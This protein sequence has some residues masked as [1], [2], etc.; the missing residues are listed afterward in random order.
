MKTVLSFLFFIATI[1]K[2]FAQQDTVNS[3]ERI[4]T[5]GEVVISESTGNSQVQSREMKKYNFRD[6]ANS[7][8]ILPSVALST[9]AS[10]NE[11]TV[12]VRGFDTRSVPVYIDGIPVYVP[13]DGY[14]DLGRFTNY[15]ISR[16]DVSKGFT[17]I[18]YG[19]NTLGGAINLVSKK[20]SQRMELV[21]FSGIMSG[22]GLESGISLG[23]NRGRIYIQTGL[24]YRKKGYLP[25]AQSFETS[26]SQPDHHLDNSGIEDAKFS[27]KAGYV[28]GKKSEYSLN[29]IYSHAS[30]D[31]PVYLGTDTR[32]RLRYWR[33]PYWDKQSI[34]YI[35]QTGLGEKFMLKARAWFDSFRNKLSSFDDRNY[36]TQ[37][38]SSSYNSFYNDYTFGGN[39]EFSSDILRNNHFLFSA[40]IKNDNHAEHYDNEPVRSFADNTWSA[41]IE[42]IYRVS[43]KLKIV[44]SLSYNFRQ[45]LRAQDYDAG[46]R[47][48]SNFPRNNSKSLNAQIGSDFGLSK[49]SRL[50]AHIAYKSR[51][52]TMK[53]RYSYRL[54]S[55]IPNPDLKPEDAINLGL[56]YNFIP[57]SKLSLR[58]EIFYSNLFNTIQLVNFAGYDLTQMRNTGE[59]VFK[60]AD[61]SADFAPLSF[62]D[63]Y[64]VYSYIKRKNLTDPGILFINLPDHRVFASAE[65]DIRTKLKF[66]FSGEYNSGSISSTDGIRRVPGYALGN[67][68]LSVDFMKYLQAEAGVNNIFDKSYS[69]QEGYPEAGRN[70]YISLRIEFER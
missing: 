36:N 24:S 4:Y 30:K 19:A 41:G 17:P 14:V 15:D 64:A 56:S 5:L 46:N 39:L 11:S 34:Y 42:D 55:G 22:K 31:N 9:F 52:A 63:F 1:A 49:S 21:A 38:K 13:Y 70:F 44:P 29:Y 20:P 69:L 61:I 58:S 33:W 60:G 16:I 50:N 37:Y 35:S 45:E 32:V 65:L 53:D 7:M 3:D 2:C 57:S 12:Y 54:G 6:A 40:H 18:G 25:L 62:L 68:R 47:V 26:V 48:I 43:S 67:I 8:K 51:F 10:R 66:V 59:S 23:S 27:I 28:P